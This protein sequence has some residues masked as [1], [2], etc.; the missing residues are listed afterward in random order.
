MAKLVLTL[1]GGV[2]LDCAKVQRKR[3]A[4]LQASKSV[5]ALT[6][7]NGRGIVIAEDCAVSACLRRR[8]HCYFRRP[9]FPVTKSKKF[10][11]LLGRQ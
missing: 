8:A 6:A 10:Y 11:Y 5:L 1:V 7:I 9:R 2:R 3:R 4:E